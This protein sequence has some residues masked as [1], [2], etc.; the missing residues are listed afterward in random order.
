MVQA[1]DELIDTQWDVNQDD[2]EMS[3]EDAMELIDTQ[4]D[5]NQYAA[6]IINIMN[7][8]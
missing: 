8:N 2:V 6:H 3:D 1:L 4:W 5:V 7:E